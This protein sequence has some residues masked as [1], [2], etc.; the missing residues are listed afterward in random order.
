M[1]VN[2]VVLGVAGCW[3]VIVAGPAHAQNGEASR[4]VLDGVYAEEQ[5][6]QGRARF[7]DVCASCHATSQFAGSA[8]QSTWEGR[9]VRSLFRLIRTTMPYDNP[10]GLPPDEYAAIV[11]YI[12]ELNGYPPGPSALPE[13]DAGL[14]EIRFERRGDSG[15]E[16][17]SRLRGATGPA[18]LAETP[19]ARHGAVSGR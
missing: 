1:R 8:F 13:E 10:A 5:A 6:A 9:T 2:A 12:L 11:A 15:T 3:L 14:N 4:S 16:P 18:P 17:L 7:G 19:I